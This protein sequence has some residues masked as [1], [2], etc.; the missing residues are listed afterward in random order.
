MPWVSPEDIG[1]AAAQCFRM[2]PAA[3]GKEYFLIG[4]R[5]VA[6]VLCTKWPMPWGPTTLT[7]HAPAS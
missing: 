3:Y 4:E 7:L 6:I 5:G 2:G 1:V